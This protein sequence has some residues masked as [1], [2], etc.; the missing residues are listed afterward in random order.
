MKQF[1]HRLIEVFFVLGIAWLLI[2][3]CF[4]LYQ[5]AWGTGVWYGEFSRTWAVLFILFL[6]ICITFFLLVCFFIWRQDFFVPWI[7]GA[8]KMREKLGVFRWFV[9]FVIL[10]FPVWFFQFTAWGVVFQKLYIRVSVWGLTVLLLSFVSSSERVLIG[11]KQFLSSL[12]VT[13]SAF[14][15]MASLVYVN[16]YPFSLGWSEGNRLWDYSILFGQRLYDYPSDKKIFVLLDLG[17]QLVGGWPFIF[18]GLTIGVERLW[19]G[20][21]LVIPYILLGFATFRTFVKN[22]K[23]WLLVTLWTFLFLK[24]GPIHPPLVLSAALV[25]LAWQMP[26]WGAIPL[27]IGAGYLGQASRFTWAF[28]PPIWIIMLEFASASFSDRKSSTQTWVRSAI[29]GLSGIVGGLLLPKIIA[30]TGT[31]FSRVVASPTVNSLPAETTV[32][33]VVEQ[34]SSSGLTLNRIIYEVTHQ[35]LL[36]YRL[37]P[38]STYGEGILYALLLAVGPLSAILIYLVVK[39]YWQ[40]MNLQK[41]SLLLPLVAFFVVGIVASTKIGGGGDLHNM[42]MFL[43]ALFFVGAIAL[44]NGGSDW[45]QDSQVIPF[46][47]KILIVFLLVNSSM[48]PLLEMRS[49]NFGNDVSWLKTLA[50]YPTEAALGMLPPNDIVDASLHRIQYEVDRAKMSGDVLFI[51]QRQLLTFGYINNVPFVPDYEKKLL[52]NQALSGDSV[53]FNGFY[54]DLASH[55]FSLIVTEP[56]RTPVQDSSFQFGEENNAWVKWVSEPVLCYYEPLDTLKV[57]KVQ[58]LI[59]KKDTVDCSSVIPK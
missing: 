41:I 29:L 43:I 3:S 22:K 55:R 13:G 12:I 15:I 17:R 28:A 53:Y 25:A 59:P 5:I 50:D 46:F 16:N 35:P 58:L 54:K 31:L 23:Q 34:F 37:L 14:S 24:Q 8:V 4:E 45:L 6:I 49:I 10:V 47:L 20:L 32:P 39:K 27:L 44:H 57:V 40:L 38:N 18:P 56:L 7:D 21:T 19:V 36:W 52:M 9:W 30:V 42:D 1:P 26:L 33:S 48:I 2:G 51:D 11:W